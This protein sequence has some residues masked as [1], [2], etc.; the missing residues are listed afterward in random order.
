MSGVWQVL[1]AVGAR[2]PCVPCTVPWHSKQVSTDTCRILPGLC[3]NSLWHAEQRIFLAKCAA[4]LKISFRSV[5]HSSALSSESWQFA[6]REMND[7]GLSGD[8]APLLATVA[9]PVPV[10][11]ACSAC[12]S[13]VM[14]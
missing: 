8:G 13:A 14:A 7:A 12:F 5:R 11:T 10:S 6:H 1:H 9:A 2:T 4:W 3:G